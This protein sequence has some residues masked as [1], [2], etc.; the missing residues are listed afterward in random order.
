VEAVPVDHAFDQKFML[1]DDVKIKNYHI[2]PKIYL[3]KL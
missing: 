1:E 3:I 2:N